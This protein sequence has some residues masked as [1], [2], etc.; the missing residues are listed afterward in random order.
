MTTPNSTFFTDAE[1][2]QEAAVQ[3]GADWGNASSLSH[4]RISHTSGLH[5]ELDTDASGSVLHLKF[6]DAHDAYSEPRPFQ[7]LHG[8]T[9][10]EGAR[11]LIR[12]ALT[13]LANE[14]MAAPTPAHPKAYQVDSGHHRTV[15]QAA[16]KQL[17][18]AWKLAVDPA[19]PNTFSLTHSSGLAALVDAGT[20][21]LFR[22][23]G[24][25]APAPGNGDASKLYTV[26]PDS[27]ESAKATGRRLATAITDAL[28]D[29]LS[30]VCSSH[31]Q[32]EGLKTSL[33]AL[34][35]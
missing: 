10:R 12:E 29:R 2:I 5:I 9:L 25:L 15:G 8:S 1:L 34:L 6:G 31:E 22:L 21:F 3:L 32:F 30:A 23:S 13:M 14:A 27:A 4:L 20:E 17:G 16:A 26:T 7:T 35:R 19:G 33:L 28:V 18:P 11:D 24:H